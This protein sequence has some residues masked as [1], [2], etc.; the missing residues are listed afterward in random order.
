MRTSSVRIDDEQLEHYKQLAGSG[1]YLAKAISTVQ[2]KFHLPEKHTR[3]AVKNRLAKLGFSFKRG[4]GGRVLRGVKADS[5]GQPSWEQVRDFI[6]T[7][8]EKSNQ[9]TRLESELHK[10]QT[11]Y[12]NA[13][14]ELKKLAKHQDEEKRYK[15]ALQ[16]GDINPPL[17][18]GKRSLNFT[19]HLTL[20]D[21]E[22]IADSI[23]LLNISDGIFVF[24]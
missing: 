11:G 20:Y 16:Q 15:L 12:E 1:V 4:K 14:L 21:P 13:M 24:N 3:Q 8:I 17:S 10:Y 7:A 9:V 23:P 22:I 19:E 5:N 6:L 18:K 2:K